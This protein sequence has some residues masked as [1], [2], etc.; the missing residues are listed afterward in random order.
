MLAMRI[1]Q[2]SD[3]HGRLERVE[4][5][6]KKAGEVNPDL[7]VV[8]GD[9]TH[10]GDLEDAEGVLDKLSEAGV[11]IFFVSGN[12]DPPEMLNW[13]PRN[14]LAENLHSK[15]VKF[16][17][18]IFIGVGGGSGRFGTLTELSEEEFEHI[19][20]KFMDLSELSLIHI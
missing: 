17:D 5:I 4:E 18:F 6:V 8:A 7:I 15:S 10:F 11:Q 14:K 12:C 13:Q 20:R 3:I 1:L 19:L 2:V 9:I 16:G